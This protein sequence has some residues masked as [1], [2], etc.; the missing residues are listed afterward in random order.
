MKP[1]NSCKCSI[2]GIQRECEDYTW[3]SVRGKVYHDRIMT[4]LGVKDRQAGSVKECQKLHPE[5][6]YDPTLPNR[7][8]EQIIEG[9]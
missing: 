8:I 7:T 9:L 3:K 5:R 2:Y 6:K 4:L 1:L